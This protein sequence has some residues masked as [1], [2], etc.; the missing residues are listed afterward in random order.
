M[1]TK[2]MF[3]DLCNLTEDLGFEK[4]N[5]VD[6]FR[7]NHTKNSKHGKT[8]VLNFNIEGTQLFGGLVIHG[9]TKVSSTKVTRLLTLTLL[10]GN[11][12]DT[13]K[14]SNLDPSQKWDGLQGTKT[15]GDI[16][17]FQFK[18]RGKVSIEM[19]VLLNKLSQSS[20]HSN[21]SVLQL[22]GTVVE[23]VLFGGT[24]GT[25]LNEAKGIKE[26]NRGENTDF[27]VGGKRVEGRLGCRLT[28]R[29]KGRS[30]SSEEKSKD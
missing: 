5:S 30:R 16:S 10:D 22:N 28:G 2:I 12:M 27:L 24:V 18:R 4:G 15:I 21:T 8:S 6:L 11:F 29:G 7:S 9:D 23:E 19:V 13:N 26:S 1:I 17:E 25:I 3:F 14:D 20:S